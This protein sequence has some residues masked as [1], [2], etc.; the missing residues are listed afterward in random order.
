MGRGTDPSQVVER[1][2]WQQRAANL[3]KIFR[4]CCLWLCLL[5]TSPNGRVGE[6]E[7]V[8]RGAVS[9][10]EYLWTT[11]RGNSTVCVGFKHFAHILPSQLYHCFI[12]REW[13]EF[14]SVHDKSFI[15]HNA[16]LLKKK[17]YAKNSCFTFVVPKTVLENLGSMIS[18]FIL[19]KS[20]LFW[21]CLLTCLLFTY[22]N[23]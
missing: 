22:L 12:A 3:Q 23:S 11:G 15:V 7:S 16:S 8:F 14:L 18:S 9:F 2:L 20:V 13:F 4:L 6:K 21:L 19:M 17:G 5:S 10:S 1:N